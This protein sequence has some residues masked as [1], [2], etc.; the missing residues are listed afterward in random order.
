[1]NYRSQDL[2]VIVFVFKV[3]QLKKDEKNQEKK[4]HLS[5]QE[6]TIRTF[7]ALLHAFDEVTN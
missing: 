5:G 2:L 3:L 6:I 7:L 4:H 1:M